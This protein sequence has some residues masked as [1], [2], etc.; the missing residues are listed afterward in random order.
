MEKIT[1]ETDFADM[2]NVDIESLADIREIIIDDS[3][4]DSEKTEKFLKEILNPYCFRYGNTAVKIE[5]DNSD[6]SFIDCV[7]TYFKAA[8]I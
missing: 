2:E 4:E 5:F 6:I 7:K 1:H 3:M 8:G